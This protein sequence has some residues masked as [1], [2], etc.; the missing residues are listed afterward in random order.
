MIYFGIILSIKLNIIFLVISLIFLIIFIDLY[1]LLYYFKCFD[2]IKSQ[3]FYFFIL[4]VYLFLLL[5]ILIF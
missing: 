3:F 5:E 4:K 1:I 2:I